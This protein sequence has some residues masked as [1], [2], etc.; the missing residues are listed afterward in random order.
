MMGSAVGRAATP[1]LGADYGAASTQGEV[2][3]LLGSLA[4][5]TLALSGAGLLLGLGVGTVLSAAGVYLF[6]R[7]QFRQ[8]LQS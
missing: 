4:E 7:R 5:Q 1:L 8:K 3:R 6:K 2:A